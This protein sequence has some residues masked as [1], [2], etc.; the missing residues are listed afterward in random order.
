MVLDLSIKKAMSQLLGRRYRQDFGGGTGG[1][2]GYKEREK[3]CGSEGEEGRVDHRGLEGVEI[4]RKIYCK[5][6]YFQ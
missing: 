6:I 4:I 5:R 1:K 3:S 2:G